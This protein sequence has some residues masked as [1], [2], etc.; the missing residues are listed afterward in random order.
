MAAILDF[1]NRVW[2][3][4][5]ETAFFVFF[6]NLRMEITSFQ[7]LYEKLTKLHNDIHYVP[8]RPAMGGGGGGLRLYLCF[9]EFPA[10]IV[11]RVAVKKLELHEAHV[12][13]ANIVK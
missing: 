11:S 13:R 8:E 3:K 6:V 9:T 4:K 7:N 10:K 2:M 5:L 12:P 1:C